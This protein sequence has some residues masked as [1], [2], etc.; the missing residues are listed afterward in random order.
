VSRFIRESPV[1]SS[2]IKQRLNVYQSNGSS[3]LLLDLRLAEDFESYHIKDGRITSNQLP[4]LPPQSG[5][6]VARD[7]AVCRLIRKTK[8]TRSL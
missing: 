5:Q 4:L 6:G 3:I 7:A 2:A 8:R 1:I